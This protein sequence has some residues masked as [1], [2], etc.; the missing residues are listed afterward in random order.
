MRTI[1]SMSYSLPGRQN[2]GSEG[3][4]IIIDSTSL[5]QKFY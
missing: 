5:S 4:D 2:V 1:S 3:S